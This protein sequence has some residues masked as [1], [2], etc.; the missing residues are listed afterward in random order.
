M[1]VLKNNTVIGNYGIISE[2]Y[3]FTSERLQTMM[4]MF[5]SGCMLTGNLQS[6]PMHVVTIVLLKCKSKDPVD[7]NNYW[8]IAFATTLSKVLDQVLLS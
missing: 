6:T 2:V 8:P 7:A 4:S 1:K 5:L 3:N